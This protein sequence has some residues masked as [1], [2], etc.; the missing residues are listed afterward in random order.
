MNQPLVVTWVFPSFLIAVPALSWFA[1][2]LTVS[3]R[4][5]QTNFEGNKHKEI[6]CSDMQCVT[7]YY[8]K[9]I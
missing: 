7:A 6:T 8:I 1:N 2:D 5:P 4:N 9:H 3:R